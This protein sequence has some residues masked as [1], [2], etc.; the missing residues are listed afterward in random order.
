MPDPNS[1]GHTLECFLGATRAAVDQALDRIL[2]PADAAPFPIH[3]AMRYSVFGGGKRLRPV[4]CIAG[5]QAFRPDTERVLPVAA[6]IEMVHTYSLIHDDLP[7]MDDDDIRRGQESC[8]RRF[9]EAIAILAGDA[10]LTLAF[11]SL[12]EVDDENSDRLRE[13]ARILG[14]AAGTSG[15]M[16]AGQVLDLAAESTDVSPGALETIH[17]AKTGAMLEASVQLGAHMAGAGEKGISAI[18]TY[19]RKVG[20]AFQI[21]DDI[22]DET[23]PATALG[24]TPGKDREQGKATYPSIHGLDESRRMVESLTTEARAAALELG[25][26]GALLAGLADRLR[27]RVH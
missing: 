9:G 13:C 21:V 26:G 27:D 24:K 1:A 7:A 4:L 16:I 23:A 19:G 11:T 18:R 15:G 2:P 8:H 17:R 6:A 20:L 10:L 12:A 5:Y 25:P 14:K 3:E 22:L